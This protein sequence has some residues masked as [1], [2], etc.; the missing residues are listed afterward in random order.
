VTG[1]SPLERFAQHRECLRPSPPNLQDYFRKQTL[2]N[3]AKDRTVAL[4]GRLYEAPVPLIGKKVVLLYHEHDPARVEVLLE[5]RSHGFLPL[6]DPHVNF[7]VRRTHHQ[8]E[9]QSEE[10]SLSGGRLAFPKEDSR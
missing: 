5:G 9:I 4:N 3:V 7:R 10:R 2:R 6:L 1:Q 8:I